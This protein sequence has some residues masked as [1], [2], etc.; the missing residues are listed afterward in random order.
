[1]DKAA[2]RL[3][4]KADGV[5]PGW[6]S[7]LG[8]SVLTDASAVEP[9]DCVICLQCDPGMPPEAD[10]VPRFMNRN[11]GGVLSLTN[12]EIER[13]LQREGLSA[14]LDK[15]KRSKERQPYAHRRF[16]AVVFD[17]AA[18]DIRRRFADDPGF[19]NV[20][21]RFIEPDDHIRKIAARA[22]VRALYVLSLDFG[23]VELELGERGRAT[24]KTVSP[25]IT[26]SDAEGERRLAEA[27]AEFAQKWADETKH[28]VAV[29]LGADPEFALLSPE[30]KVVAASRYFPR[31]GSAGCDSVVVRGVKRWPL[32]ELRP[33]LR[34]SLSR[35]R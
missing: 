11:A 34:R 27:V 14:Q 10:R 6:I 12:R 30:G 35:S 2:G 23:Q 16:T 5:L 21:D 17:L 26:L 13:R 29:T 1:M 24:I 33:A 25:V 15:N 22:A 3:W 4:V 19:I 31:Q 7:A 28:G 9:N 32:A 18:V 20:N 8:L